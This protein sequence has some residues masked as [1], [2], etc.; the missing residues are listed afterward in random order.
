LFYEKGEYDKAMDY[1]KDVL[2]INPFNWEIHK[3]VA[4]MLADLGKIKDATKKYETVLML[5]P[6]DFDTRIKYENLKRYLEYKK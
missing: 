6:T 5:N 4:Q 1:Y 3:I 2:Q